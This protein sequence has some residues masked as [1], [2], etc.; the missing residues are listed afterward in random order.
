MLTQIA[1]GASSRE[2]GRLFGVSTRTV[3]FHRANIKRKLGAK[4][5]VDLLLLALGNGGGRGGES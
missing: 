4:D 3:E 5:I 1:R 2:I